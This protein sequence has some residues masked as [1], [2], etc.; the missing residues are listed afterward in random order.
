VQKTMNDFIRRNEGAW[1]QT[2]TLRWH[3][4]TCLIRDEERVVYLYL[5]SSA[6]HPLGASHSYIDMV[7]YSVTTCLEHS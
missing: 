4:L 6:H 5:N 2:A 3:R 7:I 1:D